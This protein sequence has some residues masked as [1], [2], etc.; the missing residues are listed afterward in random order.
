MSD[1][2]GAPLDLNET[3]E[4]ALARLQILLQELKK[5]FLKN[6][7]MIKNVEKQI[8]DLEAQMRGE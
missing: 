8:A 1:R 6:N 2:E 7:R 4:Q 3:P 5:P